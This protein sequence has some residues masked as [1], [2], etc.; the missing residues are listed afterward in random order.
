MTT[1][2]RR[3]SIA[4]PRPWWILLAT[5]VL[6]AGA[7]AAQFAVWIHRHREQQAAIREI[8]FLRGE[9]S[10]GRT[11]PEWLRSLVGEQRMMT[12]DDVEEVKFPT[13]CRH[14]Q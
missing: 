11:G 8:Q 3:L 12:L 2:P 14:A 5:A 7:I 10:L 13:R 1:E 9:Y 6:V 4:L